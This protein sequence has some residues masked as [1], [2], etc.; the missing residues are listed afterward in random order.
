VPTEEKVRRVADLAERIQAST[1]LLLTEYRGL[2]VSE[3]AELR[4]SLRDA[5][6]S[7]SVVKN[8]IMQ[9]AAT[10]VGMDELGS[11]LTGPSAVAFVDGDPVSAAKTLSGV[12]KRYPVLVL[13]GGW[14][15]GRALTAEEARQLADLESREVM[16][17]K[18]AGMVQGEIARAAAMFQAA[19]ARFLSVLQAYEQQVPE[20]GAAPG[21]SSTEQDEGAAGA[22]LDQAEAEPA[23]D[24]AEAEGNQEE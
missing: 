22:P 16:L 1:A 9:R 3:I 24:Q 7:F 13:K 21:A 20:G 19:Q 10:A 12:A 11:L 4:R 18:I 5:Q 23:D 6:T 15:D 8:S 2:T 14:M 17:S